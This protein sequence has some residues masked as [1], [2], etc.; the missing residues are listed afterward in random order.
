MIEVFV[1]R[2]LALGRTNELAIRWRIWL[3]DAATPD[4]EGITVVRH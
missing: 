2:P 4:N 3:G 1:V